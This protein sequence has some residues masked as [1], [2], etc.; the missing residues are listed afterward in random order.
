MQEYSYYAKNIESDFVEHRTLFDFFE[1]GNEEFAQLAARNAN[2]DKL[3]V[4]YEK[5]SLL[6]QLAA[7]KARKYYLDHKNEINARNRESYPYKKEKIKAKNRNYYLSHKDRKRKYYSDHKDEIN[8]KRRESYWNK[9]LA[10]LN[11]RNEKLNAN[12]IF[13]P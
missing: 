4:K 3:A 8:A 12:R 11:E 2:L 1:Q 13:I 6:K 7:A 10:D 9:K 5:E